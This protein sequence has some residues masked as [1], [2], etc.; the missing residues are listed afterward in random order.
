MLKKDSV[1]TKNKKYLQQ[2]VKVE[3]LID[4]SIFYMYLFFYIEQIDRNYNSL[5]VY[6][7]NTFL[8]LILIVRCYLHLR[9]EKL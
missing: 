8:K 2:L 6:I 5:M 9:G 7:I 3:Q 4:A 1:S